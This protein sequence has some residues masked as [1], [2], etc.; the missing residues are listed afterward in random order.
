MKAPDKFERR[1]PL[2]KEQKRTRKERREADARV[3]IAENAKAAVDF[4]KYRERLKA[5][6]LAREAGANSPPKQH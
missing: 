5:E 2:T 1:E 6:R 3:A 4:A